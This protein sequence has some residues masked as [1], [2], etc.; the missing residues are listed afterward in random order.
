M[1]RHQAWKPV[2]VKDLT[3]QNLLPSTV[4][5]TQIP[6]VGAAALGRAGSH[7]SLFYR[8]SNILISDFLKVLPEKNAR[9]LLH[10]LVLHWPDV[11]GMQRQQ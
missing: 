2:S 8:E 10:A 1:W 3:G 4:S 9:L 7:P 6:A 5:I 11:A